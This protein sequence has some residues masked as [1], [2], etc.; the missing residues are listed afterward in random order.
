MESRSI[1]IVLHTA[2]CIIYYIYGYIT[3]SRSHV[4][5]R[6]DESLFLSHDGF[7]RRLRGMAVPLVI[8]RTCARRYRGYIDICIYTRT[9]I[10]AERMRYFGERRS[11]FFFFFARALYSDS[12]SDDTAGPFDTL[13][14]CVCVWPGLSL[15]YTYIY[16]K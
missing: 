12:R 4:W 14:L 2:V 6:D 9:L 7:T 11:F 5:M 16:T 15:S 8:A 3:E 10:S 1:P 13:L